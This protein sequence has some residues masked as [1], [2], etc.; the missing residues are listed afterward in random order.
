MIFDEL[1]T[2]FERKVEAREEKD[3][4][5]HNLSWPECMFTNCTTLSSDDDIWEVEFE[6][7]DHYVASSWEGYTCDH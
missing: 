7:Y 2:L 3:L 6:H 1:L 5:P 4:E